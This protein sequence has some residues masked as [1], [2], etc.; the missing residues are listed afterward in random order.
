MRP[1]KPM[2]RL[3][4]TGRLIYRLFHSPPLRLY[5][6]TPRNRRRFSR[7]KSDYTHGCHSLVYICCSILPSVLPSSKNSIFALLDLAGALAFLQSHHWYQITIHGHI[8]PS[9]IGW[10]PLYLSLMLFNLDREISIPAIPARECIARDFTFYKV[11]IAS[12][13]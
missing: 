10:M 2:M 13:N 8:K 9:N 11:S 6:T 1:L 5:R 12:A 7:D 4:I 3:G